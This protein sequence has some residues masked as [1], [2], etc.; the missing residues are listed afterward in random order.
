MERIGIA[1]RAVASEEAEAREQTGAIL[2]RC[3]P[4]VLHGAGGARG[5][6]RRGFR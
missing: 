6:A 5:G 1:Q 3:W 2:Q 4:L